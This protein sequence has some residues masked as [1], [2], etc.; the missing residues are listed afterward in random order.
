MPDLK[1]AVTAEEAEVLAKYAQATQQPEATVVR[2]L[3]T[4]LVDR[5]PRPPV[6]RISYRTIG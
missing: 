4:E 2:S 6:Q 3:I 1:I 5:M